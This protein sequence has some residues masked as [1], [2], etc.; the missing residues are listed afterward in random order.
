MTIRDTTSGLTYSTIAAAINALPATLTA[1]R[2]LEDI[3]GATYTETLI[4]DRTNA[5]LVTLRAGTSTMPTWRPASVSGIPC[6]LRSSNWR[7]EGW[8]IEAQE[9]SAV[10][11]QNSRSNRSFVRCDLRRRTGGSSGSSSVGVVQ[12]AGT[13]TEQIV[14]ERC[15]VVNERNTLVDTTHPAIYCDGGAVDLL[16]CTLVNLQS[17]GTNA[18]PVL[19]FLNTN[20]SAQHRMRACIVRYRGATSATT[21]AAM[22]FDAAVDRDAYVGDGNLFSVTTGVTANI[23][24]VATTNH[25]TL[26]DWRTASGDDAASISSDATIPH[27]VLFRSELQGDAGDYRLADYSPARNAAI[28]AHSGLSAT[29]LDGAA[30]PYGAAADIGAYESQVPPAY[31]RQMQARTSSWALVARIEGVGD[32][33]GQWAFCTGAPTYANSAFRPWLVEAPAILSERVDLAGGVPEAGSCA[34]QIL[35]YQDGLTSLLRTDADAYTAV[36]EPVDSTETSIEVGRTTGL[37][38]QIVW[39]GLEAMLVTAT[40]SSPTRITVTRGVL[41]TTALPHDDRDPL[42]LYP[43]SLEGRRFTVHLVPLDATSS[44]EERLVGT[45]LID[46]VSWSSDMN[47]WTIQG[48]SQQRYLDRQAP[49]QPRTAQLIGS[50]GGRRFRTTPNALRALWGDGLIHLFADDEVFQ[51]YDPT[52]AMLATLPQGSTLPVSGDFESRQRALGGTKQATL[53]A[54]ASIRQV[55]MAGRDLRYSPGPSPSTSR[56]SGTW[57]AATHWLD[58]MLI[59][60]L[61]SADEADGL[62]LANRRTTGSDWSRSNFASLPP[63]YGAGIPYDLID[64][65]AWEEAR[66]RTIGW[67]LPQFIYGAEVRSFAELLQQEFLAPLGAYLSFE[68]GLLRLVLSRV[69]TSSETAAEYLQIGADQVL[70][71]GGSG[72]GAYVPAVSLERSQVDAVAAVRYELGPQ[73]VPVTARAADYGRAYGQR[74]HYGATEAT[75][76]VR[77]SGAD[78]LDSDWW[79]SRAVSR[80][81]RHHRPPIIVQL[82]AD[83]SVWTNAVPGAYAAVTLPELPDL[84]TG[85]RGW[86]AAL[87]EVTEREVRADVG[88]STSGTERGLHCRLTLRRYGQALRLARICPSAIITSVSSAVAT[89][90]ANRYTKTNAVSALPL[91]DVAGF[92]V[93]DKV[94]LVD[95]DGRVLAAGPEE[96]TAIGT[97]TLTLSGTFSGGLLAGRVIT[98]AGADAA[99]STQLARY[100]YAADQTQQ[101]AGATTTFKRW[102]EP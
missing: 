84:Q 30:V 39:C 67:R 73:R 9:S 12:I 46:S 87:C 95:R 20:A 100:A 60:L 29:D 23:A 36:V 51:A 44:V 68:E 85:A 27:T 77:V 74:G 31:D 86:T 61:S 101:T 37:L 1:A 81:F 4:L 16:Y 70:R 2:T 98:Y 6:L 58:L 19:R 22:V 25:A 47:V 50:I 33:V 76:V 45:Y 56:S 69:P 18:N 96:V 35:D 65:D 66:Q 7:I 78:P 59:L 49:V 90:R 64:W 26:A 43:P 91:T 55:F 53:E 21:S 97:N 52:P 15:L 13:T 62:E 93:G 79:A 17:S 75:A 24:R 10:S 57:T 94:Q 42:H 14:L 40:A 11:L 32:T 83:A 89:V 82:E 80:L 71:E 88:R 41:G 99:T 48:R 92:S 102:G 5:F 3:D 54:G 72:G 38:D 63:G 34:L 8:R 28:T